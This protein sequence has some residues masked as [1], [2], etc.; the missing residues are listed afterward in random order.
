[1]IG[2]DCRRCALAATSSILHISIERLLR[3]PLRLSLLLLRHHLHLPLPSLSL[4]TNP[5]HLQLKVLVLVLI[6]ALVDNP[7]GLIDCLVEGQGVEVELLDFRLCQLTPLAQ[8]GAAV[9]PVSAGGLD[10]VDLRAEVV[11]EAK[12][13]RRDAEWADG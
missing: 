5:R 3:Q 6:M 2:F 13:D 7:G 9:P 10:E 11:V 8:G 1:M 4:R 12:E